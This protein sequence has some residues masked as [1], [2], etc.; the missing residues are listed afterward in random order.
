MAS[1]PAGAI[2]ALTLLDQYMAPGCV[3]LFDD[4]INYPDYRDHEIK[5]LWEWLE[6][7][8]RKLE[9]HVVWLCAQFHHGSVIIARA[10]QQKQLYTPP[11][12]L[13]KWQHA[14]PA[15]V[16]PSFLQRLGGMLASVDHVTVLCALSVVLYDFLCKKLMLL[17]DTGI[18]T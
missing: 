4:L 9:V 12:M 3:L 15:D 18:P 13:Y 10:A 7:T 5:A 14:A 2:D 11:D 17:L 16:C 6:E 8:G 1:A